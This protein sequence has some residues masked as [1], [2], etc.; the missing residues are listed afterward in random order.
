MT[1]KMVVDKMSSTYFNFLEVILHG[2]IYFSLIYSAIG[3]VFCLHM[4]DNIFY[5]LVAAIVYIQFLIV[6]MTCNNEFRK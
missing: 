3:L 4:I 6:C 5:Q 2:N 1:A